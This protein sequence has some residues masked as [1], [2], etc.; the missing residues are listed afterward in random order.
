ME[1]HSYESLYKVIKAQYPN[2]K[3][4]NN[5]YEPNYETQLYNTYN[6]PLFNNIINQESRKTQEDNIEDYLYIHPK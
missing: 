3:T 6:I 2:L 4:N 1:K 5:N